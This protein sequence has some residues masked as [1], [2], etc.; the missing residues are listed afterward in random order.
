M[1]Y[2]LKFTCT[3]IHYDYPRPKFKDIESLYDHFNEV[4]VVFLT[5]TAIPTVKAN[6]LELAGPDAAV[7]VSSVNRP[8]I[9]L[10]AEELPSCG[11]NHGMGCA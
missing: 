7:V 3:C 5:A 10:R 9:S 8:N 2:C 4:P 1:S 11:P 6:L